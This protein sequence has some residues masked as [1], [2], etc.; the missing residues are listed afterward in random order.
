MLS[1]TETANSFESLRQNFIY[2]LSLDEKFATF[3]IDDVT[4]LKKTKANAAHRGFAN[5]CDDIAEG[6]RRTAAQKI[7]DLELMLGQIANFCPVI[8][9]CTIINN[10]TSLTH[11]WQNIRLHYGFQ[12][13]GGHFLDI[14][15][16]NLEADERPEDLFQRLMAFVDDNLM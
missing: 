4:W 9:R 8:A 10:S 2:T 5:D 3:L 16:I 6:G 14:Y 11:I 13:T 7:V 12:S 15:N 1:K